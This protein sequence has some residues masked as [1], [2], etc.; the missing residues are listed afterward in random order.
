M[1]FYF[2][3]KS[4]LTGGT[5]H[6]G[7][8]LAHH[9]IDVL[10]YQKGDSLTLVDQDR[11]KYVARIRSITARSIEGEVLS[12]DTPPQQQKPILHLGIALLKGDKMDWAIQKATELGVERISPLMTR[13]VVS[14]VHKDK[15]AH[16]QKRW[17]EIA[18]EGSQQS[19]R[20]T[21]P[22]IDVPLSLDSFLKETALSDMKCIFWE[23]APPDPL[24]PI[25]RSALSELPN[26]LSII[27]GPEGGLE[28]EEVDQALEKGYIAVSLGA[29]PVRAETAAL[30]AITILQY[31]IGN[32]RAS[33]R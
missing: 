14:K 5:V 4:D 15:I 13:R 3:Q 31:E 8:P 12:K 19:E 7:L 22:K 33:G 17:F 21:I 20:L 1:P 18:K 9:L 6:I 28:K 25:I 29:R 30:A 32:V 23:K 2:I 24:A 16:Q 27:I 10:R 26:N 11:N